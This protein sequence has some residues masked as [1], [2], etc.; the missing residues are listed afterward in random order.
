M[1]LHNLP[2][3][4]IRSLALSASSWARPWRTG[5]SGRTDG[6]G[7][8]F[9]VIGNC[10]ARG[11]AQ[12]IRLLRPGSPVT[13]I[14]MGTLRRRYGTVEAL[15]EQ[16]AGHA[17]VYS[18]FVPPD[19]IPG[20][21]DALRVLD[22]RIVRFPTLVFQAYHPDM[23]YA[24]PMTTL[25]GMK[26]APSPLG[27]YHSAIALFAY[28]LGLDAG[29]TVRLYREDVFRRLGYLAG[30]DDAVRDLLANADGVGFPL[31]ADL[32][33]WARRGAFMH[34]LNHPKAF[35][36][37]DIARRLVMESGLTPEPVAVEDYLGDDLARDVVWP[38]YPPIAEAYGLTGSYLFKARP[39]GEAFPTL[40]DLRGFID[41]SFAL[42]ARQAPADIACHRVETWL[43]M[44]EIVET[45]LRETTA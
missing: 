40:Y 5:R 42:Y 20:G 18:Q 23:V 27:F 30:W 34:L 38:I 4:A 13:Y 29:Q 22:P 14:P 37:G 35:V 8:S 26:L 28:R 33:R 2:H 15:A 3:R 43:G 6:H 39:R 44:P 32:V 1:S 36:L 25:A 16:I 17:H 10:Q 31:G 19:L 11:I 41:A 7:P 21:T 12:A 24:G 45:F 9:A